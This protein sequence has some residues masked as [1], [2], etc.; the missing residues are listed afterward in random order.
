MYSIIKNVLFRF[1]PELDHRVVEFCLRHIAPLPIVSDWMASQFCY[2]DEALGVE[3][4]GLKFA[5]PVG[6]A[7]GFDKNATMIE[8]L[9]L[10]GFGFVELGSITLTP[11]SGNPK[12]R[13]FRFVQEESLQNAMGFNNDGSR[14]IAQRI[15]KLYPYRNP[16]VINLGKNKDA[17]DAL[18]NYEEN[19]KVFKELGDAYVF[20]ISSPN[21]PN[22]R[23]L[24]NEQ[25]VKELFVMAREHTQK[26]LFVKICPD[27]AI[28]ATL[29]VCESALSGGASGIIATNT[30]TDYSLLQNPKEIGGI[31]GKALRNKSREV[32]YEISKEFFGKATLISSGGIF[33]GEEAYSRIKMGASLVEI[34]SALIFEGPSVCK[35]VNKDLQIL[36]RADGFKNISEAIGVDIK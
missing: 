33:D 28:D 20:N 31:S 3:V 36:L 16:L 8:G 6:L 30:T 1:D 27:N 5:N 24:Q 10:M 35:R 15:A 29:R 9:S 21:T 23:D 7:A 17:T 4:E 32:F 34:Y 22:L 18:K 26:P 11:Q 25:F 2:L 13:I 12:P 14:M 19:L